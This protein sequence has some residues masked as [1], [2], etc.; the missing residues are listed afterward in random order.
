MSSA[1]HIVVL[2]YE[3]VSQLGSY[4]VRQYLMSYSNNGFPEGI[5]LLYHITIS[6][7][8]VCRA[9]SIV[10]GNLRIPQDAATS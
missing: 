7:N 1:V 3:Y 8:V 4:D 2:L 6:S 9:L 10:V 5:L